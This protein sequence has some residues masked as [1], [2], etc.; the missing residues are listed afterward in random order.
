MDAEVEEGSAGRRKDCREG[1][2][3]RIC[4]EEE[5]GREGGVSERE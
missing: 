2:K 3:R 1:D 5:E 4:G